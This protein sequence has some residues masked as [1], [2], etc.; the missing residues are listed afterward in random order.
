MLDLLQEFEHLQALADN[1]T[2]CNS[3]S[4][5]IERALRLKDPIDLLTSRLL[6]PQR[7]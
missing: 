7:A 1:A 5:M 4:N 3:T 2:R 6:T